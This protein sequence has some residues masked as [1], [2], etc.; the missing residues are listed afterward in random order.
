MQTKERGLVM[1]IKFFFRKPLVKQPE[2]LNAE[3]YVD[4]IRIMRI[5]RDRYRKLAVY[6]AEMASMYPTVYQGKPVDYILA[7]LEALFES[8]EHIGTND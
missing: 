4:I 6:L 3:V 1:L 7:D 8:T 5:E 2:T